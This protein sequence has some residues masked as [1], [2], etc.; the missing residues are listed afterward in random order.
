MAARKLAQENL[1]SFFAPN[2]EKDL[3][4]KFESFLLNKFAKL[5]RQTIIKKEVG[6]GRNIADLVTFALPK[7]PG[8]LYSAKLSASEAVLVNLLRTNGEMT[9]NEIIKL[10]GQD[11]S[12]LKTHFKKLIHSKII[13]ENDGDYSFVEGWPP[14]SIRSYEAKLK[15]WKEAIEQAKEY[16]AYANESYVVLPENMSHT[17]IQNRTYFEKAGV[18]L[19]SVR[20]ESFKILI[21]SK[22]NQDFDWRR[23]FLASR[24]LE[25]SA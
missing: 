12:R 18:G 23:D 8:K 5:K 4:I 17:A 20:N 24:I 11:S 22:E 15:N 2:L 7:N 21:S 1:D 3:V 16:F 9:S 14:L 19:I 6:V 10:F 13:S 25:T